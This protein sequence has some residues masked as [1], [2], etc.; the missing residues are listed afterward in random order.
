TVG[1]IVRRVGEAQA[2][3]DKEMVLD[4]EYAAELPEGKKEVDYL[5]TEAD[6]VFV[7]DVKKQKHIE[8]SHGI[9]Y[10]GWNK[11]GQRVTLKRPKV[12]MTTKSIDEFWEEVKALSANEYAL[13]NTQV[14]S[15]RDGGAGYSPERFKEVYSQSD[16]PL[17][18]QL[19]EYHIQHDINRT[20][21]YRKNE[22]ND[23]VREALKEHDLV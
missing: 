3:A 23:K 5:Y 12:I 2:A 9:M 22:W 10:E 13:Q 15:N 11:N 4:L 8:V 1:T 7:R 14:V 6:G 16:H 20:F 18:H 21:G 19:D 17:L